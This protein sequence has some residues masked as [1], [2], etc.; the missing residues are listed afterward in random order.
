M[1]TSFTISNSTLGVSR[2]ITI[3]DADTV[4]LARALRNGRYAGE[5]LT[6]GQAINRYWRELIG[7]AV[8]FVDQY[9]RGLATTNPITPSG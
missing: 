6:N 1:T 7:E 2:S 4:R 5:D 9:E 3:T 8:A